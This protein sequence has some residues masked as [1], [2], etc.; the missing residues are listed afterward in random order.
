MGLPLHCHFSLYQSV[1]LAIMSSI[2]ASAPATNIVTDDGSNARIPLVGSFEGKIERQHVKLMR[3][4]PKD[5]PMPEMRKRL[6]EDGYLLV[7]NLLPR[8]EVINVRS[9]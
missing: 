9:R 1:S 2:T 8:E 5:T 3:P 7:K 4:T 6:Q